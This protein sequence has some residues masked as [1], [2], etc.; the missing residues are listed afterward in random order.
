MIVYV[1]L[2]TVVTSDDESHG[3][4]ATSGSAITGRQLC[5]AKRSAAREAPF[6]DVEQ[7]A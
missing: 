2:G 4:T 1:S 5:Q 3:W 7:R 6:R